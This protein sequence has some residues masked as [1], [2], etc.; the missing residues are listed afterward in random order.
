VRF[1]SLF[2]RESPATALAAIG[3]GLVSGG[4]SAA[5][6]AV[7]NAEMAGDGPG[8]VALGALVL[9]RLASGIGAHVLLIGL[10]QRAIARLRVS[11]ADAILDAP[12]DEAER[13][14]ADRFRA[15]FADDAQSVAA[16][17]VNAPYF[18]VNL[19]VVLASMVYLS[20]LS[21]WVAGGF[22]LVALLGAASYMAPVIRA[23]KKLREARDAQDELFGVFTM[24]VNGIKELKLNAARRRAIVNGRLTGVADRV[25]RHN[26]IGT[27]IYAAAANWNRSLFFVY[28]GVLL[29]LIPRPVDADA[30]SIAAYVIVLLYLAA[31]LEAIMNSLP[32]LAKAEVALGRVE[33]LRGSVR[34]EIIGRPSEGTDRFRD[35]RSIELRGVGYRY[36]GAG[37]GASG[38]GGFAI[39]PIDLEVGRSEV[40]YLHGA[41]GSGKTTFAKLL[42]GLYTPSVGQILVDGDRIGR[43]EIGSY[44]ELFSIVFADF[45]VF[46][47]LGV[48]ER[49]DAD[50]TAAYI[51]RFG[52]EA[53]VD[54]SSG[55][56][57]ADELSSGQRKRL[58]LVQAISEDRPFLVFD[59]WASYQD[60]VFR[61]VFYHEIVPELAASG[62]TVF[63]VTHD[64][65]YFHL[66]DRLLDMRG[67][68]IEET[69]VS[70]NSAS[71]GAAITIGDKS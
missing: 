22:A 64:D 66:A 3:L 30:A 50:R 61:D 63:V 29:V 44:R 39:G 46:D 68:G 14:G 62:R 11:I 53:H 25:R 65:R 1:V 67:G 20:W 13:I 49:C 48:G 7:V 16:A 15:S 6:I 57:R 47:P 4:V 9:V 31:P 36:P 40:L 23:H 71:R 58:A 45:E 70:T 32:H 42:T 51:R 34:S 28:V 35:W 2:L 56:T 55:S 38:S 41:N 26:V 59:E 8:M 27:A 18:G 60:V 19:I 43:D 37:D 21:L 17:V 10:S 54:L 24:V 5:L 33:R 52:L 69:D 12:L